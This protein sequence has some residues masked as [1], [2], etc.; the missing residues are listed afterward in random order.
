MALGNE[1]QSQIIFNWLILI[2]LVKIQK[3]IIMT[4]L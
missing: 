4:H 1:P 2:I 3:Y